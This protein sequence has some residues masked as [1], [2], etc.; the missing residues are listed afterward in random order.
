MIADIHKSTLWQ[1][2]CCC[3]LAFMVS[4]CAVQSTKTATEPVPARDKAEIIH[5][6]K[7]VQKRFDQAVQLLRAGE[8]D[9]AIPVLESVLER[10]QRLAA[11]YVNL[12]L[13]YRQKGN[14]KQVQQNLMKALAI[15]ST[16]PQA[17]NQL[18]LLYRK[19]GKFEQAREAYHA[20]LEAH[21]EYLPAIR[22]LGI[23]CDIYLRDPDCA[24]EQ[25]EKLQQKMPED[26]TI[27]IW[28]ADLKARM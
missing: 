5:V 9:A 11:P 3:M 20:A 23:L 6:D 10:E 21:P 16:Q 14:D 24:L 2:L 22:N 19:Q 15:D 27:K 7:D 4:S 1:F 18:G 17:N 26:K 8:V 13:A 25:Y 28:I 12:A